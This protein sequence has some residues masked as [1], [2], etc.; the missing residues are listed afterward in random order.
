MSEREERGTKVGGS[1]SVRGR[2]MEEIMEELS[3]RSTKDG[4]T[5]S[6]L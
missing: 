2:G 5:M 3:Q 1:E 4:F 6:L